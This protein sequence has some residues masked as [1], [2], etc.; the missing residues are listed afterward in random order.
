MRVKNNTGN[1]IRLAAAQALSMTTMNVNI[2][3]TALVGSL[4]SPLPWLA[5]LGLSLQFMMSM[6]TTLPASL[7]MVRFGRKPIFLAGV[8][9]SSGATFTQG[10]A[11]LMSSFVLFCVGSMF[12]GIALGC[13]GFYRYAAADSAEEL[14]KPRAISYVLAGGLLA[15]FIGPE[16]ARNTVGIVSGHLFAGCFFTVALVQL[17]SLVFLSGLNIK[18]P[19]RT[20]FGGRP[21]SAFF[22]MPIFVVGAVSAAIGYAMMSYMMTATPL[23]IVNVVMLGTSANATII[24]WHVVA[25]FAPAFFTGDLIARF[26]AKRILSSGVLIYLAAIATA[27][28]GSSFWWYFSALVLMGLGWNFLFIGGSSLVAS[29]AKPEERG[30]VQGIADLMTTTSVAIASLTAGV[31]HSQFGWEVMVL[32]ALVPVL[33]VAILLIWLIAKR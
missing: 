33:I 11:I 13:A 7:L 8:L 12:L 19:K 2:I 4:L 23:Q 9:V 1:V 10:V 3:N 29:V 31:L 18:K 32:S 26:G 28:L 30:R 21:I 20:H 17:I 16:I 14:Q 5:T 15:A 27:L 25:M 22:K 24:Q 6:L